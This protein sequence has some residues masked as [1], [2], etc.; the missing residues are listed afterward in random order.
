MSGFEKPNVY[1]KYTHTY[2]AHPEEKY[3]HDYCC[4]HSPMP[5]VFSNIAFWE[6][7]LFQTL[8]V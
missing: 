6:M 3:K 8:G 4:G 7:D 2:I 5:R 1:K